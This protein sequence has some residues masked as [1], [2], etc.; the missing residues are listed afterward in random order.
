MTDILTLYYRTFKFK[1]VDVFRKSL[2]DNNVELCI[3][4]LF[5]NKELRISLHFLYPRPIIPDTFFYISST[6]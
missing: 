5:C 4:L 1:L 3:V 6:F 2:L